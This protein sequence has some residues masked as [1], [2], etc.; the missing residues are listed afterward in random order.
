ME[1]LHGF[2][3][4]VDMRNIGIMNFVKIA[5]WRHKTQWEIK[6]LPSGRQIGGEDG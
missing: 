5:I 2:A 1:Q 6:I 3:L 4:N